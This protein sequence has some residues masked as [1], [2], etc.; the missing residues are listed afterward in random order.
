MFKMIYCYD[1]SI[2]STQ[3]YLNFW[4]IELY[5]IMNFIN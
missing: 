2:I 3:I 5:I 4:N 1:I